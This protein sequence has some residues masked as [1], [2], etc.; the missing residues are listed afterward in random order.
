MFYSSETWG[1]Y[2]NKL[3]IRY[4]REIEKFR[5]KLVTFGLNKQAH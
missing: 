1:L 5:C 2:Y 3:W 4:L